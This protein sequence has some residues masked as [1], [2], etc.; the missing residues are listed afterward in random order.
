MRRP[1]MS[2]VLVASAATAGCG[3][4]DTIVDAGSGPNMV[5]IR[6]ECDPAT[7]N[8]ALGP[9]ACMR[10]GNMTFDRFMNELTTTQRVSAW[11]FVP[12]LFTMR[13]GQSITVQNQGGEVHTFTRVSQFGGGVVPQLNTASGNRVPAA[14]CVT[15][16]STAEIASGG[17]AAV[18]PDST[19]GTAYYQC[20]IHPWMRT[21]V[22]VTE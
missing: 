19:V 5:L 10:Q 7:F 6:D 4:N 22:R 3:E 2:L 13:V 1:F 18:P 15:L 9:G 8:A 11:Q 12:P 16:P 21:T 17:V 14:E 20:C